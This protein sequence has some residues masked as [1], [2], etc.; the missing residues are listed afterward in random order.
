MTPNVNWAAAILF[1]LLFL[2]G[3]VVFVITP[4]VEKGSWARALLFGAL[5]GLITYATYD[6]TNLAT[7]KDWP[8]ALTVVDLTGALVLAGSVS[9]GTYLIG[10][11]NSAYE[12]LSNI[13]RRALGYMTLW[14]LISLIKKRNDV[15]DVAWG[16]GF[17]LLA[18]TSFFLSG[19]SGARGILAGILV[20]IWGLRLAW[21]IHARHRGKPEDFRYMAWRREWGKWFYARSYAQ[22]YLLQ[23][24]LLFLV[25]LPVLMINRRPGGTLGLFDGIGVCVWLFGFLFESVGDAELARFAKD[26]AQS[27]QDTAKRAV[28]LHPAP[29]LFRRGRALWWGIWLMAVGVPGGWFGIVG[30][31]TITFLILK[32]SG[33]PM[34]EKKMAENPDFAEYKRRTSVF[35]PWFPKR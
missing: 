5:F 29:Q 1:Y 12:L 18:W 4:A 33:I 35:L 17:V 9:V 22:V 20:S 26:P 28:A 24:A 23:G 31:L 32:V 8:L 13:G 16:L 10:E 3:L 27:G 30:P 7:L 21:H 6:L 2:A 19:G 25:A 34:L 11:A 14:F 15:A